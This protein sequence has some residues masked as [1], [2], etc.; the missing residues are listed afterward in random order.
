MA[1]IESIGTEIVIHSILLVIVSIITIFHCIRM[2]YKSKE[3]KEPQLQQETHGFMT[4]ITLTRTSFM[5]IIPNMLLRISLFVVV[6][7]AY[8][9][10]NNY[11]NDGGCVPYFMFRVAMGTLAK[12]GIHLFVI[13]RSKIKQTEEKSIWYKISYLMVLSDLLLIIFVMAAPREIGIDSTYSDQ[14]RCIADVHISVYIWFGVS[15]FVIATYCLIAFIFPLR[16]YMKI[17]DENRDIINNLSG[18][19]KRIII[20]SSIML[21]STMLIT[22]I[23]AAVEGTGGLLFGIDHTINVY[24]VVMQFSNIDTGKITSKCIKCFIDLFQPKDTAKEI[25]IIPINPAES[26]QNEEL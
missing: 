9:S 6:L 19:P 16:K 11:L 3:P 13:I 20:Y 12:A 21:I 26:Q 8:Y 5:V 1:Y 25:A 17:T 22:I 24:C 10:S 18:S 2:Y 7:P 4:F 15:D 23:T 14:G